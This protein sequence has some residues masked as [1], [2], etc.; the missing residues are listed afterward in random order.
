MLFFVV[1]VVVCLFVC[2][3]VSF[4]HLSTLCNALWSCIV[5]L[6]SAWDAIYMVAVGGMCVTPNCAV[7]Y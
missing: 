3:F 5:E 7:V 2:L 4:S 1:V 6:G